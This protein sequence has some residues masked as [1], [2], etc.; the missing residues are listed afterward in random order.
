MR[1]VENEDEALIRLWDNKSSILGPFALLLNLG[2]VLYMSKNIIRLYRGSVLSADAIDEF[3][4]DVG[5]E[6]IVYTFTSV[7]RN[8]QFAEKFGNVL[9]ILDGCD[10]HADI[11][12]YSEFPEEQ[13]ELVPSSLRYRIACVEYDSKQNKHLIYLTVL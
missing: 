1:L 4:A 7:T 6:R 13:D 10:Q 9:F 12:P 11:S 2:F 3:R 8:R 5:K